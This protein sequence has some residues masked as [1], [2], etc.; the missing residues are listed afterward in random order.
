MYPSLLVISFW[1]YNIDKCTLS[2]LSLYNRVYNVYN[3]RREIIRTFINQ[4]LCIGSYII[5]LCVQYRRTKFVERFVVQRQIRAT[6]MDTGKEQRSLFGSDKLV[7][8]ESKIPISIVQKFCMKSNYHHRC[9]GLNADRYYTYRY[10][11]EKKRVCHSTKKNVILLIK[12]Y[13]FQASRYQS[14]S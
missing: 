8:H 1:C 3:A 7:T 9:Y 4:S 6:E 2:Y 13:V 10:V 12:M 11:R 14:S 5:Y